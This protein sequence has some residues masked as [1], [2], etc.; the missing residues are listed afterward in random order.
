VISESLVNGLLQSTV[1]ILPSH[2]QH[3]KAPRQV[4]HRVANPS[5]HPHT[6]RPAL[7]VLTQPTKRGKLGPAVR[8]WASINPILVARARQVLIEPRKRRECPVAQEALIC[9]PVPRAPRRPRCRRGR[10]FIPTQWSSE[11]S[12]AVRDVVI[13]VGTDDEAIELFARHARRTSARLEMERKCRGGYKIFRTAA[14]GT[15]V[16]GRLVEP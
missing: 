6:T 4:L 16:Y 5:E 2:S 7:D 10:W 1:Q 3:V 14:A 9:L 13:C 15:V 11:Q 12:R 8:L